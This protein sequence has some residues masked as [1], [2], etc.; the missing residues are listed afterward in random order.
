V[1][2]LHGRAGRRRRALNARDPA[3]PPGD[4]R[5]RSAAHDRGERAHPGLGSPGTP[6]LDGGGYASR[7]G[8]RREGAGARRRTGTGFLFGS[9]GALI[10]LSSVGKVSGARI[11]P[12]VTLAFWLKGWMKA[13][14][15]VG[16]VIAQ[17]AGGILG[18]LPLWLW[19]AMGASVDFGSPGPGRAARLVGLLDRPLR[20]VCRGSR[21]TPQRVIGSSRS[22]FVCLPSQRP[23]AI[24]VPIA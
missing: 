4:R 21:T 20:Q 6:P 5:P 24:V 10:A 2:R 15:A 22:R 17:L 8:A 16:Y 1:A 3:A 11:N 18:A 9:V 12:A 23:G 14:L 19:G 7:V 13:R